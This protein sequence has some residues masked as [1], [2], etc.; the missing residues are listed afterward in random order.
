MGRLS[1]FLLKFNR[2]ISYL[3]LALVVGILMTGYRMIGYFNFI[4]RGLAAYLHRIY[5]NVPFIVLVIMHAIISIRISIMRKKK[6]NVYLDMLLILTGIGF[7]VFFSY[8]AL[9]LVFF[10]RG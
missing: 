4:P 2:Y 7:A 9:S 6:K 10:F 5:L 3:L 1:K 8:F